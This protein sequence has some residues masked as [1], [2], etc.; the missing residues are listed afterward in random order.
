MVIAALGLRP[1]RAGG[2]LRQLLPTSAHAGW[3]RAQ[4]AAWGRMARWEL[5]PMGA[6]LRTLPA[7]ARGWCMT[8]LEP[9]GPR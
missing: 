5:A 3:A 4:G 6:T 2:P 8:I 7:G 9:Q 1:W